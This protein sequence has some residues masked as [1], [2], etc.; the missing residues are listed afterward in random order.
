VIHIWKKEHEPVA[1]RYMACLSQVRGGGITWIGHDD[2][3]FLRAHAFQW[4]RRHES[5]RLAIIWDKKE[6][7][8]RAFAGPDAQNFLAAF[9]Q[10]AFRRDMLAATEARSSSANE[11]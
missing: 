4:V 7:E 9:D 10:D 5:N 1:G 6:D 2:F 3:K 11:S 8:L